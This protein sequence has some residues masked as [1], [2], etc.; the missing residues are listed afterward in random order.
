[1]MLSCTTSAMCLRRYT[2]RYL[3]ELSEAE[4][5]QIGNRARARVLKNHTSDHRAAEL[6]TYVL[7]VQG[8]PLRSSRPSGNKSIA[9]R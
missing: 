8:E 3:T 7:E 2:L 9:Q 6:E 4:R 1:M 5:V